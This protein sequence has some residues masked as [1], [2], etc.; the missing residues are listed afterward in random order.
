M[1]MFSRI[2]KPTQFALQIQNEHICML[3]DPKKSPGKL[4]ISNNNFL[5]I[6]MSYACTLDKKQFI[7]STN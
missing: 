5:Q 1:H 3:D 4:K 6:W 7:E 2:F